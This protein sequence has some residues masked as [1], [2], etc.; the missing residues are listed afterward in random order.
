MEWPQQQWQHILA[1]GASLTVGTVLDWLRVHRSFGQTWIA[2]VSRWLT[3]KWL[4]IKEEMSDQ[5]LIDSLQDA[6]KS[7]DQV[8]AIQ[9]VTI[10]EQVEAIEWLMQNR[11]GRPEIDLIVPSRRGSTPGPSAARKKNGERRSMNPI[12]PSSSSRPQS[13]SE[14]SPSTSDD[15]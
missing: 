4:G 1:A 8:I 11:Q 2:R 9:R 14:E 3:R 10:T 6:V 7:K 13:K 5:Q 12:E 15:V